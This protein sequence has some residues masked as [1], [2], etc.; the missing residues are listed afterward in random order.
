[1][2]LPA[3]YPVDLTTCDELV[4]LEPLEWISGECSA[5]LSASSISSVTSWHAR[6]YLHTVYT[7]QLHHPHYPMFT[8][9]TEALDKPQLVLMMMQII[10]ILY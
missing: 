4:Q 7:G 10:Q 6:V 2:Q 1:M 8:N 9:A 5:Q 3:V